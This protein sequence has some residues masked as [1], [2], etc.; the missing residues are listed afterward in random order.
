VQKRFLQ[1]GCNSFFKNA[2]IS[3]QNPTVAGATTS[4]K[5]PLIA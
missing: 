1:S 5:V 3:Q 2:Q 4:A